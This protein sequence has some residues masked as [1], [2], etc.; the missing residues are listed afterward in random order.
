MFGGLRPLKILPLADEQNENVF[1]RTGVLTF[2]LPA[3]KRQC[4]DKIIL[5]AQRY[6]KFNNSAQ[7]KKG[8]RAA[9]MTCF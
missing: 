3:S 5:R 8:A 1:V 9:N 7:S 6:L 2:A 4:I